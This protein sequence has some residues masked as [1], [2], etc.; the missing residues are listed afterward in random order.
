MKIK[1]KVHPKSSKE[2]IK[3]I[4]EAEFEVWM[5]QPAVENKANV[6]LLKLLQK[7]F[8]AKEIKIKSGFNSKNKI[9]EIKK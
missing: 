2:E 5:K 7:Y 3:R 4:A 6:Y 1:V 9:V 8:N